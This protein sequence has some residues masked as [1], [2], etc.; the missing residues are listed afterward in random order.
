V[1]TSDSQGRLI[2][3]A[4]G[5][6]GP[7]EDVRNA[8]TFSDELPNPDARLTSR[9]AGPKKEFGVFISLYYLSFGRALQRSGGKSHDHELDLVANKRSQ[10]SE[11]SV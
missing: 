1:K 8:K 4:P 10:Q 11:L 5:S 9:S 6:V 2:S 3:E 7:L